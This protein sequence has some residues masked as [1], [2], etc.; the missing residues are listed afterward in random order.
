[1]EEPSLAKEVLAVRC[2]TCGPLEVSGADL[3]LAN[4]APNLIRIAN[5]LQKNTS[6]RDQPLL[7][8]RA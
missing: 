1:M 7:G 5:W 3:V 2:L 6:S 4:L 8:A